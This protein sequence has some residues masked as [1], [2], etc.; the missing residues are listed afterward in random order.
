MNTRPPRRAIIAAMSADRVIGLD[1][2]IPWHYSEDLKRFKRLTTGTTIIMG[3]R[4]FE[5]MSWRPLPNRRN[6]VITS[7][8]H[9]GGV[10]CFPSLDMALATCLTEDVWFI[11]GTRIFAEAMR[12]ADLIDLTY[13]PDLVLEGID[14]SRA[15]L[16][17]EVDD[18]LFDAGPRVPHE[19]EP[20]LERQVFVRRV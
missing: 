4:T 9:L 12:F 6:I 3:R 5:S 2:A 18:R 20:A 17:P 13:V 7:R 10:E 14:P 15:A 1:N 8:S 11:G 19:T 16:F